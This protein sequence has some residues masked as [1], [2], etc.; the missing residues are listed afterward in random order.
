MKKV[1][2]LL[3]SLIGFAFIP[4]EEVPERSIHSY[5][6]GEWLKFRIHF[7]FVN[8][9]YATLNL[10]ESTYHGQSVYHAKGKG[11]TTGAAK[12]FYEIDDRYESVFSKEE[13]KPLHF[14]RRVNE[15]G[16][17]I[18]R[19]LFF[20][21]DKG[22]VLIKDFKKNTEEKVPI[23]NVQDMMSAFYHLRNVDLSRISEGDEIR[24]DLFFDGEKFPFKLKFLKREIL[25]TK[26][27]DIH[28]WKIRPMVQKGRVFEGQESLTVWISDDENKVPLRIKAALVV[29][30]LKVDLEDFSG[31]AHPLEF[32]D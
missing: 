23:N 17:R 22:E 8:A 30:S 3:L 5:Q 31:L 29:G 25:K 27:G 4:R 21:H 1:F 15:G 10:S 19:D 9:G 14:I 7:G 13:V 16:Y 18:S 12:F 11:W 20:D 24:E 6:S 28:T 32:I 2:F 26:F